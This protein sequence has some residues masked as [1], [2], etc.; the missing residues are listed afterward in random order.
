MSAYVAELRTRRPPR[1]SSSLREF[2]E[3]GAN[4]FK[5]LKKLFKKITR[6]P[7]KVVDTLIK[8]PWKKIARTGKKAVKSVTKLPKKILGG[9][10]RRGA[11]GESPPPMAAP[12]GGGGGAGNLLLWGAVGVVGVMIAKKVRAR[13]AQAGKP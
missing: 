9:T 8:K 5:K 1:R 3:L 6:A 4:P 11:P 10:K 13:R 12:F 2:D 7:K